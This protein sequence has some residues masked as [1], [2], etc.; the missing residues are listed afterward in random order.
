MGSWRLP[1][2]TAEM[3]LLGPSST[4]ARVDGGAAPPCKRQPPRLQ[5]TVESTAS[6]KHIGDPRNLMA[7]LRVGGQGDGQTAPDRGRALCEAEQVWYEGR[8]ATLLV[9]ARAD[10]CPASS[11]DH[12][13]RRCPERPRWA[14]ATALFGGLYA[15]AAFRSCSIGAPAT[16]RGRL[17]TF[18]PAERYYLWESIFCLPLTLENDRAGASA[19]HR[20]QTLLWMSLFAVMVRRLS[21]RAG[22]TGTFEADLSV[23]AFTQTAPMIVL[24]WLPD[25]GCY[26]L[27]VPEDRYLRLVPIYGSAATTWALVLSTT[28]IAVTERISWRRALPVVGPLGARERGDQRRGGSDALGGRSIAGPA[29]L[30][31][32]PAATACRGISRAPDH[33]GAGASGR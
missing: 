4:V 1:Q 27:R 15:L 33:P 13:D 17:L 28:G 26:L 18:I 12:G 7:S 5:V 14:A 3:L 25:M 32:A 16:A 20:F 6:S 31:N 23:L 2:P 10:P 29:V 9:D 22:G 8:G 19:S 11:R 21:A 24:F 30:V